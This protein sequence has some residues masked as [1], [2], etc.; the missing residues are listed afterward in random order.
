MDYYKKR[1]LSNILLFVLF[2]IGLVLQ[3][4]GHG[5]NG[6]HG[7]FIQFVSLIILLAVLYIYNKRHS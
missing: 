7:L 1:R 4:V 5:E 6:Y 3:F 2:V